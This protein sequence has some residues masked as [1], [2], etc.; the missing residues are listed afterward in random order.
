MMRHRFEGYYNYLYL[1]IYFFNRDTVVIGPASFMVVRLRADI[2]GV[3]LMVS[4]KE[5]S[6]MFASRDDHSYEVCLPIRG[7]FLSH[8]VLDV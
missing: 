7:S 8:T 6:R 2:P 5:D 1:F 3:W 4:L